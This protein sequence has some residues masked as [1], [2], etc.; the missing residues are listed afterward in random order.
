M[1]VL[2]VTDGGEDNTKP[3]MPPLEAAKE[4][5]ETPG[6]R[7]F[8]VGFDVNRPEWVEQLDG[9]ARSGGGRYLSASDGDALH[10]EMRT[11]ILGTPES[12][13]VH[14]DG[15]RP[16]KSGP[17]G[18]SLT[19]PEGKY[20]FQTTFGGQTFAQEFWINAETTTAI[21][22]DAANIAHDKEAAQAPPPAGPAPA[23][24]PAAAPPAPANQFC[25]SCGTKL[26]GGAKFCTACG[27]KQ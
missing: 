13:A 8:V 18:E 17:F 14:D 2:L 9:L 23:V 15:G 20:K 16:I 22:F 12:F 6:V 19:L 21:T 26:A 27:A 11:A 10:R 24:A 25:T 3:P 4:L 5:G 1:T 7:W